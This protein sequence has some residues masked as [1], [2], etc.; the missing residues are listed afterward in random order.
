MF[1]VSA[2]PIESMTL[3]RIGTVRFA[4]L[5]SC[6]AVDQRT[7]SAIAELSANRSPLNS[8]I[9]LPGC[10]SQRGPHGRVERVDVGDVELTGDRDSQVATVGVGEVEVH[11]PVALFALKL[12]HLSPAIAV[13]SSPSV[14]QLSSNL[15]EQ[16]VEVRVI[17]GGGILQAGQ[18][19]IHAPA[20]SLDQAIGKCKQQLQRRAGLTRRSTC[21]W[22]RY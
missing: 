20:A 13:S 15:L 19:R 9:S 21:R 2:N 16:T 6:T 5:I 1:S 12:S 10:R 7:Q 22:R 18:P 11:A 17:R 3:R 8:M 14:T 4:V